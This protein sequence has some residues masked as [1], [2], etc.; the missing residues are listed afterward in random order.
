[1]GGT[2]QAKHIT[3]IASRLFACDAWTGVLRAGRE[4]TKGD[5]HPGAGY[6][7]GFLG[8]IEL[9]VA[10]FHAAHENEVHVNDSS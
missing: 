1:M 2:G 3:G 4:V 6:G 8:G 10:H 7:Y 5:G 9:S